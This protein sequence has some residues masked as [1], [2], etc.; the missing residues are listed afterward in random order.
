[1][2]RSGTF[3]AASSGTEPEQAVAF[4]RR[5]RRVRGR[6]RRP[7][8]FPYRRRAR[9]PAEYLGNLHQAGGTIAQ[10]KRADLVLLDADP[11]ADI[12]NTRRIN[13][14]AAG[15]ALLPRER[16]DTMLEEVASA[17]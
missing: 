4:H 11:L 14:V 2:D 3:S 10:G 15:G 1:M 7:A 8:R 17:D 9:N 16:L 12:R 13:A 5:P 6:A